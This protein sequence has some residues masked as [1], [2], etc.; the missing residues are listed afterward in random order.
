MKPR[1]PRW[2]LGLIVISLLILVPFLYQRQARNTPQDAA[3]YMPVKGVHVDHHDIVKGS[4]KTGQDVTRACLACHQ[5]AAADLMKTSH[6]TWESKAFEVPWR[7]GPITIGKI[8]QI[9]NFCIGAQGNENKCMTCHAGYG[10]EAGKVVQQ[11]NRQQPENPAW[12][13]LPHLDAPGVLLTTCST[14]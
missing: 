10:W 3:A 6:W 13:S 7:K 2:I 14:R 4:F 1:F 11:A 12:N 9:N 5:D 8:N